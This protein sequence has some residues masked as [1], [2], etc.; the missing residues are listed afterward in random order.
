MSVLSHPFSAFSAMMPQDR[1]FVVKAA[2][3]PLS[4]YPR[5]STIART[6]MS[7]A[8]TQGDRPAIRQGTR[9]VSYH[10]LDRWSDAIAARLTAAGAGPGRTIAV[11]GAR[12]PSTIAGLLGVLKADAAYV[13]FDPKLPDARVSEILT[14]A[15]PIAALA[16]RDRLPRFA[17]NVG[18][19]I[20][21]CT[22]AETGAPPADPRGNGTDLAYVCYTSGST[23]KPK[24]VCVDH[25]GVLR[26]TCGVT[27]VSARPGE[28]VLQASSLS[29]DASTF[30]IFLPLLNGGTLVQPADELPSINTLADLI[31]REDITT[32][33]LTAGLFRQMVDLR[34]DCFRGGR[35]VLAGGDALSLDHVRR[36]FTEAPDSQLINGYGPTENTTFSTV[37][38]LT[39]DVVADGTVPIGCPIDNSTA[40]VLDDDMRPVPPG[41]EGDL[42]VGGDG[43]ARGYLGMPEATAAVF[44]EDPFSDQPGARLYRTGDR[45]RLRPDGRL[46]FLGR[47]DTQL[48][49]RG[50]R[51]EPDEIESVL[52]RFADVRDAAVAARFEAGAVRALAAFIIPRDPA[53]PPALMALKEQ[54]AQQLPDWMVPAEWRVL[55]SLPLNTSGKVDRR[56]LLALSP[57]VQSSTSITPR[58]PLE[59]LVAEIWERLLGRAGLG[60][61]ED[62]FELG[63]HSLLMMQ[64]GFRLEEETGVSLQPTE[65][66]SRP[67]IR[68]QAEAILNSML[69]EDPTP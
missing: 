41:V 23:G 34:P 38:H 18:Q 27:Y 21:L 42:H 62:F 33:W 3:G 31:I 13:A 29:F 53:H 1:A 22:D 14:D 17:G 48:K 45:A 50:Y 68:A 16:A 11:D 59:R 63:G 47:A 36:F 52:R 7:T 25:R 35:Q 58:T 66:F 39:G 55:N 12:S 24:G 30:E 40:W 51:V 20:S 61:D 44:R 28:R 8:R 57:A 43:V 69:D 64:L 60:I 15:A 65:L 4:A 37:C 56:A 5:D 26:L 10:E 2:Q 6:F 32:L 49:I 54:L 9:T 19:L 67:T 46:E